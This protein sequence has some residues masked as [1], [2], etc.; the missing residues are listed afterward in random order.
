MSKIKYL[1]KNGLEKLMELLG[2]GHKKIWHGKYSDWKT[3]SAAEQNKYNQCE[4]ST[5]LENDGLLF[6]SDV[7][8]LNDLNA[9]TSNAVKR[10][11]GAWHGIIDA[12]P[13]PDF[14]SNA[15]YDSRSPILA[16]SG[17]SGTIY[18]CPRSGTFGTNINSTSDS[19]GPPTKYGQCIFTM[20]ANMKLASQSHEGVA[21]DVY[22]ASEHIGYTAY[23]GPVYVNS[24]V[25]ANDRE[26][27]ANFWI[28]PNDGV[29]HGT[30]E[31]IYR[32]WAWIQIPVLFDDDWHA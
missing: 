3:K 32:M 10:K 27:Q 2:Q 7:I 31:A 9:V 16:R 21:G 11:L 28:Y 20:P 23:G 14:A 13:H 29:G 5:D 4:A 25:T 8:R 12:T 18:F 19:Y 6:T 24:G 1:D 26:L 17:N 30:D 22:D 15:D